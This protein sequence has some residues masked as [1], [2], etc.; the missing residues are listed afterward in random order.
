MA[1]HSN[2]GDFRNNTSINSNWL[3]KSIGKQVKHISRELVMRWYLK[4]NPISW[5]AEWV[6]YGYILTKPT[7][8]APTQ[9]KKEWM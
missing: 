4:Y 3:I 1:N 8:H 7:K 2:F 5:S 6:Y 9:K